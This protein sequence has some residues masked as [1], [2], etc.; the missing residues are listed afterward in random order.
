MSTL[1]TA[2]DHALQ[3]LERMAEHPRQ[4]EMI[5]RG[6][7]AG[8]K[9]PEGEYRGIYMKDV[10]AELREG[11]LS[12]VEDVD[13]GP[14]ARDAYHLAEDLCRA[15]GA[16]YEAGVSRNLRDLH[17]RLPGALHRGDC[18][19]CLLAATEEAKP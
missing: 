15:I 13:V 16:G 9:T 8:I 11:L 4:A 18:D 2:A 7:S 12:G 17:G 5:A 6:S 10:I 19:G 3:V 14:V 1:R